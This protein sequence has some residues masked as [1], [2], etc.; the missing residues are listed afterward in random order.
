[1]KKVI[2]LVIITTIV[3]TGCIVPG[4]GDTETKVVDDYYLVKTGVNKSF[5]MR[6]KPGKSVEIDEIVPKTVT[7]VYVRGEYIF[8]RHKPYDL[9]KGTVTKG[10]DSFYVISHSTVSVKGPLSLTE[11]EE[12][13]KRL[14][15]QTKVKFEKD[16]IINE[17]VN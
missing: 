2:L 17:N 11:F 13:L 5:L 6:G 14:G 16:K 10:K 7:G 12:L 3:L 15:I 4:M 1:M 8:V 9:V